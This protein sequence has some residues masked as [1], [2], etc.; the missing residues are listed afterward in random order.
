M[1]LIDGEA[2]RKMDKEAMEVFG[3]DTLVLMENAGLRSADYAASLLKDSSGDARISVIVGKGNNGGDGFV[4]ARH[5]FNKGF[6]VEVFCLGQPE[7][8]SPAAQRNWETAHA[9]GMKITYLDKARDLTLFR[10]KLAA[11]RMIVDA[12]FGSG[13]KGEMTGLAKDVVEIINDV[14]RPVLALDIPSGI[15]ADSGETG[16]TFVKA[17]YTVSF[18]LPK[19]GNI[20]AP[21]GEYNGTLKVVDISFPKELTR[22]KDGDDAVI[23]ED[24]ALTKM[25]PRKADTH[26]GIYGH[27]LVAGGSTNM[28]GSLILAGKGALKAGAGLVTYMMPWSLHEAVRAQNLEAMTCRLPENEDGSLGVAAAEPILQQTGNKILVLG[29][30]LSRTEESMALVKRIMEDVNCPLVLD[31][32]ALIALGELEGRKKTQHP[33]VLT[34]HPGEMSRILGWSIR[35]VQEN[36]IKAAK[37][38]AKKFTAVV[39]L[40]GS[41]TII[42]DPS[43]KILVNLTGNAGM[44]TGGMGDVLSGIIGALLGQG[45]DPLSAAALGVYFHGLAGDKAAEDKGEMGLNAGDIIDYLPHVLADY[46]QKLKGVYD[47]VL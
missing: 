44:A 21:G 43:G 7:T 31:A 4:M 2:S 36:R 5:L 39:V 15:D 47:R 20:M 6:E 28:A 9:M 30:G 41:R 42:A 25:R 17:D 46:E 37:L 32:D 33:L 18:A 38:A 10:V 14:N 3:L 27:V 1:R 19:F 45:L 12:I 40:K 22:E 11:S 35:E 29:M 16:T 8:F 34:P 13:F 23:D 24:W 26:K